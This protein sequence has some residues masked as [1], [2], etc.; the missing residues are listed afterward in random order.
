MNEANVMGGNGNRG[1]WSG[2]VWVAVGERVRMIVKERRKK[3][4]KWGPEQVAHYY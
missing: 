3:W 2:A 1:S 4:R